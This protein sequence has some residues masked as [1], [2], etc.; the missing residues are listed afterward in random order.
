MVVR[1]TLFGG[2]EASKIIA[3]VIAIMI[4]QC[5]GRPLLLC[6]PHL[7]GS[8]LALP[9]HPCVVFADEPAPFGWR[10]GAKSAKFYEL[11]LIIAMDFQQNRSITTLHNLRMRTLEQKEAE[12]R[13]F[14]GYRP[15]ELILPC[16][17]SEL[18]GPAL[19]AIV[20]HLGS[21]NY[22]GHVQLAWIGRR[23]LNLKTPKG[24]L[25]D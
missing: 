2:R 22:L 16:L 8:C 7:N 18:A 9:E 19:E 11:G 5:Y 25:I 13:L 21:A 4:S 10:Y 12:L 3:V 6:I 24:F 15:L 23:G 1:K 20:G 14:S 17:Y